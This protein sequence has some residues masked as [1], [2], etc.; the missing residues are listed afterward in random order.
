MSLQICAL[1]YYQDLPISVY[2]HFRHIQAHWSDIHTHTL[3]SVQS[4][5]CM[6]IIE[7]LFFS[8]N[9]FCHL[10]LRSII[11]QL[12]QHPTSR[13]ISKDR[14]TNSRAN[15]YQAP[16]KPLLDSFPAA[17]ASPARAWVL[18]TLTATAAAE[19]T[20]DAMAAVA[21]AA[22]PVPVVDAKSSKN[23][24]QGATLRYVGH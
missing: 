20:S 10:E 23:T 12:L 17:A 13:N 7:H 24:C 14:V 2:Y 19:A 3:D 5:L 16:W 1:F 9:F 6:N 11:F 15:G 22:R 4:L 21:V 18:G 8:I